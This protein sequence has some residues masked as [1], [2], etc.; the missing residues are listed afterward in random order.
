MKKW[1]RLGV[2]LTLGASGGWAVDWIARYPKP[3]GYVSDFA[4]VVDAAGKSQIEAYATG[5]E[6]A[7]GARIAF[8]TVP[9]LEG[10]PVE[11]V[12]GAIF[13]G[14]GTGETGKPNEV[15]LLFSIAEHRFRL[16]EGRSLAAILPGGLGDDALREMGP[17][18]ATATWATLWLPPRK[19]SVLLS[20][21]PNMCRLPAR[22]PHR[23]NPR[24]LPDYWG[25]MP[26]AAAAAAAIVWLLLRKRRGGR[27][28]F[29]GRGSGGFGAF[30]SGDGFGGFGGADSG[31]GRASSDW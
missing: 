8:V 28:S 24:S 21:R 27:A 23:R 9:S 26:M 10:E 15:L 11:D 20:P 2:A 4:R 3:E 29:G 5:V 17:H 7:T 19:P 13:R 22:L 12:A 30:D 1:L 6:K 31:G 25:W 14:W 18:Y 16:E